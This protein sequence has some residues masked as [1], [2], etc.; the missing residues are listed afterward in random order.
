MTLRALAGA[1]PQQSAALSADGVDQ[2]L[3][4]TRRGVAIVRGH[5]HRTA[6]AAHNRPDHV[7]S[8]IGEVVEQRLGAVDEHAAIA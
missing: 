1:E 6:D 4:P 7:A 5:E 3:G 2:Q 8:Q